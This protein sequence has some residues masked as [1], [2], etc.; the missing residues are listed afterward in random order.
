MRRRGSSHFTKPALRAKL[1]PE[2][3]ILSIKNAVLEILGEN[4]NVSISGSEIAARLCVTRNAVW[5]SIKQ[6]QSE[7]FSIVGV[8][9]RGY[10]LSGECAH[11]FAPDINAYLHTAVIGRKIEVFPAL[12]ST[13]T[14]AKS[15][16]GQGLPH[17]A[18]VFAE[19]QTGGKGRLGRRFVSSEGGLYMS[20]ILR[21]ELSAESVGL[22]TPLAAVAVARGIE[23]VA[24]VKAQIKWVNDVFVAGEKICGILTEATTSVESGAVEFAVVGIGINANNEGFPSEL[25]GVAT[26]IKIQTGKTCSRA[27]LAAEV[28]NAFE[29]LY[30]MLPERAF[31]QEYRER[32]NVLGKAITVIPAGAEPYTATAVAIDENARLVVAANGAEYLL[33]SGEISIKIEKP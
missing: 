9:N 25:E 10:C 14:Y 32:S 17:G 28:L 4:R 16:V 24:D 13:I 8:N 11:L 12:D 29:Q 33:N 3:R 15:P 20:I 23:A 27:R 1:L 22:L 2:V 6:L 21:P 30:N 5:K 7:G 31:L 18:A 19:I 26:S